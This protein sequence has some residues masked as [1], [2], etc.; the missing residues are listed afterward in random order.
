MGGGL[1][2]ETLDSKE[3]N[4]VNALFISGLSH[5]TTFKKSYQKTQMSVSL[6]VCEAGETHER[7]VKQR[8]FHSEERHV[9]VSTLISANKYKVFVNLRNN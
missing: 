7:V 2:G 5:I 9:N 8:M 6:S 3:K 1:T 4:N